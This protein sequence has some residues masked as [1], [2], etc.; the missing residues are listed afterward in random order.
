MIDDD[1]N[2][3]GTMNQN[4]IKIEPF[5]ALKQIVDEAEDKVD[6][7]ITT[8]Y[9]SQVLKK[10][11]RE[12]LHMEKLRLY[13]AIDFREGDFKIIDEVKKEY[14]ERR[15]DWCAR[16]EAVKPIF[17]DKESLNVL[18][19]VKEYLDT[20]DREILQRIC[21]SEEFYFIDEVMGALPESIT[22]V[23]GGCYI[24]DLY[25]QLDMLNIN[26][27]KWYCFELDKVNWEKIQNDFEHLPVRSRMVVENK[28]LSN[29]TGELYE[30]RDGICSHIVG[31][32]T[33]Y[34]IE[35]VSM[36]DYFQKKEKIDYIKLDIEGAE[37][38][39]LHGGI[40]MIKRDRPVMAVCIYHKLYDYVR[41]AEY[42]SKELTNYRFMIRQHQWTLGK[43]IL[44]CIP[45]K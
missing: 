20:D 16:L 45:E 27:K 42:L 11:E 29:I 31:Y 12:L 22:I 21:T 14:G 2:K 9:G 7:V 24:G 17:Q 35:L 28:G 40:K 30:E 8:M 43:T 37:W 4:G 44:Y 13:D 19:G 25:R 18:D 32:E 26:I 34:K 36:D 33:P 39:A 38:E 3:W 23:D 10:L 15:D 6:L 5:S 1:P 41:I